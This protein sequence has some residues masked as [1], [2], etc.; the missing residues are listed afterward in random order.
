MVHFHGRV[1]ALL[2]GVLTSMISDG[3]VGVVGTCE[4]CRSGGKQ[5]D[6]LALVI[7]ELVYQYRCD[8]AQT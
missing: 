4:S 1:A 5:G 2:A 8:T 6:H 3:M 7:Q